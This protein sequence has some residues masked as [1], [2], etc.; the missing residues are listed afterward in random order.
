MRTQTMGGSI[1]TEATDSEILKV[2]YKQ[3]GTRS[4]SE[5]PTM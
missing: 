5:Y 3:R 2:V 1:T 4:D